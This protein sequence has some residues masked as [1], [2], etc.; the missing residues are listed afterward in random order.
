MRGAAVLPALAAIAG[1]MLADAGP[2]PDT[3]RRTCTGRRCVMRPLMHSD[4]HALFSD[5]TSPSMFNRDGLYLPP[6]HVKYDPGAMTRCCTANCLA[7]E[8]GREAQRD[9]QAGCALWLH[10]SSLN[11][12]GKRWHP[13]L[14]E[15]CKRDC[16]S[17]KMWDAHVASYK[18]R[19]G[20]LLMASAPKHALADIAPKDSKICARGCDRYWACMIQAT[21]PAKRKYPYVL[22]NNAVLNE[23]SEHPPS[24]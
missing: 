5:Q 1:A 23:A 16:S 3:H 9:C 2:V 24:V 17:V 21:Y 4:M 10:H 20:A 14:D 12:A 22:Y 8:Q 18:K 13:K 11:W 6:Q 15:K 19:H 7:K